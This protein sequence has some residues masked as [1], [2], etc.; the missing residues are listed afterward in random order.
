MKSKLNYL[1]SVSLKRKIK[2]KWFVLANILLAIGIIGIINVDHI[3]SFFGGDFNE[4][5][6]IYVI[7]NTNKAYDIFEN[8]IKTIQ[9]SLNDEQDYEIHKYQKNIEEAS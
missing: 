4:K 9:T 3:I 7:D 6:Q 2:T 8:Q 5:E 1:T